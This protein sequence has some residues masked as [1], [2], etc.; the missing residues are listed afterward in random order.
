MSDKSKSLKKYVNT[1]TTRATGKSYSVLKAMID[2]IYQSGNYSEKP[3]TLVHYSV[4]HQ[5]A[6]YS[7]DD[8]YH[9]FI[10]D[11]PLYCDRVKVNTSDMCI[12]FMNGSR[13]FFK[14]QNKKEND[15]RNKGL[16]GRDT[17]IEYEDH[18]ITEYRIDKKLKDVFSEIDEYNSKY[19]MEI[20]PM[21]DLLKI[22]LEHDGIAFNGTWRST[23]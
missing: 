16:K 3:V 9:T 6:K 7:M 1:K 5:R 19:K 4:N 23:L 18:T 10:K 8:F 17:Y 14:S 21:D 2:R 22:Y 11:N 15:Y 20:T 12:V 13:I